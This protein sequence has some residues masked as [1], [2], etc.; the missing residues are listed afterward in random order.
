MEVIAMKKCDDCILAALF[1]LLSLSLIT[2]FTA[3]IIREFEQSPALE[4]M[5]LPYFAQEDLVWE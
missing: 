2:H 4:I 5:K 1:V 3:M